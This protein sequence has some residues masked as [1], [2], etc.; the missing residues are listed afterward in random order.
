MMVHDFPVLEAS[1]GGHL[2]CGGVAFRSWMNFP[3]IFGG[4][5]GAV[6]C[7]KRLQRGVAAGAQ[8]ES[9]H[10]DTSG[11]S[12]LGL[13]ISDHDAVCAYPL[14]C[15]LAFVALTCTE[16]TATMRRCVVRA[17]C[18]KLD[19]HVK[20]AAIAKMCRDDAAYHAL[21]EASCADDLV[22]AV[23]HTHVAW[24]VRIAHIAAGRAKAGA[25]AVS[26]D[27]WGTRWGATAV[28]ADGK[29]PA[30]GPDV[31]DSMQA[32]VAGS[33]KGRY[34]VARLWRYAPRWR[35]LDAVLAS[36]KLLPLILLC[37]PKLQRISVGIAAV[38][39]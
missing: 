2:E 17:L 3:D 16:A 38:S 12:V 39:W 5:T 37:K 35:V 20:D 28:D 10:D 18:K 21:A 25:A 27:V 29:A 24:T 30:V 32:A 1:L 19:V 34:S 23:L 15:R 14:W 36:C 31:V 33:R 9:N 26:Y 11:R 8:D 6:Q 13:Q 7:V 22:A 4:G